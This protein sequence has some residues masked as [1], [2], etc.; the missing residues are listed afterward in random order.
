MLACHL[1]S[2]QIVQ[3]LYKKPSIHGFSENHNMTI[4]QIDKLYD[5]YITSD[6]IGTGKQI[7]VY[8]ESIG[9]SHNEYLVD[10]KLLIN[11]LKKYNIQLIKNPL[12][13]IF[14]E[15]SIVPFANFY[16]EYCQIYPDATKLSD[17]LMYY[18]RLN[19]MF[20]FKKY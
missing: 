17:I 4:W 19:I 7:D 10:I 16:K 5:D 11:K 20:F 6:N 15:T 9:K 8:M 18:S 3:L 13:E 2:S 14:L 12:Q 1:D